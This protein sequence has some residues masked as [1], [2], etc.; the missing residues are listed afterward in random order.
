[1]ILWLILL[2]GIK[3][4]LWVFMVDIFLERE[5]N[6]VFFDELEWGCRV[7]LLVDDDVD[8]V[9]GFDCFLDIDKVGFYDKVV[10]CFVDDGFVVFW[11]DFDDVGE[12]VV[13]F[14]NFV[15]D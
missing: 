14:E 12:D 3:V 9:N 7:L 4:I 11:G 1:M 5:K 2:L 15:F 8:F 13:K 6:D 10:V